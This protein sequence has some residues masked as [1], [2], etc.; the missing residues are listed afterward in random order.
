MSVTIKIEKVHPR[1]ELPIKA[2][3]SDAGFDLIAADRNATDMYV[4]YDLG[5][6]TE[7]PLGYYAEIVP[8]SSISKYDMILCNSPA[9]IDSSYR[10]N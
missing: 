3:L 10:G 6:R 5:F 1:A 7:I 9:T 2:H 4:E 8:R